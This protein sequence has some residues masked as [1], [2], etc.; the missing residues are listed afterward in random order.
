[1][2]KK[3][4]KAKKSVLEFNIN[5][6]GV[7]LTQKALFT[8]HLSVMLRA[9]LT[10]NEALQIAFDSSAGKLKKILKGVIKSVESGHS[11]S[12]SMANYPKTFSGLLI[13]VTY[14]GEESGTLDDSM[15]NIA[16]QLTKEKE[17]SAK[18]KGA[19]LYPAVVMIAAFFLGL[20]M[21][22]FVLP[23]ITPLFEGMKME[24]PPTTR[25][26]IWFSHFVQDHSKL[27]LFGIAISVIFLIW[28]FKQKFFKPILHWVFL[29]TPIVSKIVKNTNISRFCRSL[30]V[31]LKSGLSVDEAF[32]ITKETLGNY[33]YKKA[34]GT[35][36]LSVGKGVKISD[37]LNYF[38]E[39]FP[40][41]AIKMI[42]VGE[43]SGKLE[44][45]LNY[46]AEYYETEVD[47]ATKS[48]ST[49]IEPILL[50]FIGLAVGFLAISI[51]TPIYNITGSVNR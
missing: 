1:M 2:A 50:I 10:I 25:A 27:L 4:I 30:S 26:L 11:L 44:E 7:S 46:L 31:L 37:N 36:S 3:N 16:V 45:T 19:L 33:Y 12:S 49:A 13:N 35:I 24:L 43:E 34:L 39:L 14:A 42:N 8:K 48:L 21:A 15:E 18:I 40:V 23:K 9:G 32:E 28:L 47:N 51:I 5:I 17:L 29:K 41:M 38:K 6:G 20:G 22:F